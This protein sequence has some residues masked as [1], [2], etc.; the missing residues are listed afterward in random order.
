MALLALS[1][2]FAWGAGG[3]LCFG[4]TAFFGLGGYAYAVAGINFGDGALAVPVALAVATLAAAAL[5]W[6]MFYG[7]VGDVYMGVITLTVTLI[8]FKFANST[9]GEQW[10]IGAAPL[11]GFNGIPQTPPLNWPGEPDIPLTPEQVFAF[12]VLCLFGCYATAKL[13]LLT[14]FGRVAVAIKENEL[15]A[16][17]LGYDVRAHRLGVFTI[18]GAM[19]GLAGVLF[20]NCVFVSPTMFSLAYAGQVVIWVLVGGVGTFAGPI[21]ACVALQALT[22]WAGTLPGFDP[23]LL[24][25]GVLL[26]AVVAMPRGLLPTTQDLLGRLRPRRPR[27][28][29]ERPMA[30]AE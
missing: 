21:A 9:A 7:R 5:G 17:L 18:G 22:A 6:F 11:G 27:V 1:L 25:G 4:Q 24:L 3:I 20:A 15:R 2:A 28:A 10:R 30:P 19:A 13:A 29:E 14:R 26:L 16:E 12:A 8:L 23:N